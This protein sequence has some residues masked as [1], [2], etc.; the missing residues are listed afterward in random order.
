MMILGLDMR[1]IGVVSRD[2]SINIKISALRFDYLTLF[3]Y[4]KFL[5]Q[6]DCLAL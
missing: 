5:I 1:R 2:S 4:F 3:F 6:L